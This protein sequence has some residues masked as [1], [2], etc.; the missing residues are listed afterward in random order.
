VS[1][2]S[3]GD[4]SMAIPLKYNFRSL[5]K[6]KVSTILII[7]GIALVVM[8]CIF[9][10]AMAQSMKRAIVQTGCDD[11]VIIKNKSSSSIEF[12]VLPEEVLTIIK[13]LPGIKKNNKG[14]PLVSPE[15][16]N[17]KFIK[18]GT[19]ERVIWLKIR[20]VT[21]TA[22]EVYP[23]IKI[24]AGRKP[25]RGE[26][27]IGKKVPLMFGHEFSLNDKIKVGKQEHTIVGIFE[28]EGSTY[29]GEIW[30]DKE[31]MKFDFNMKGINL[32][33]VKLQS[34][35]LMNSFIKEIDENS[36]LPTA[37]AVSEVG[38]YASLAGPATFVLV[39]GITIAVLMSL[40]A[41]FGGM[42]IMYMSIA[43]RAREIGTLRALGFTPFHTLIS[44]T[45]ESLIITVC[46]WIAGSILSITVNGY[47][48]ELFEVAFSIKITPVV[49]LSAFIVSLVIVFFGGLLPGWSA[50]R[51]QIIEALRRI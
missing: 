3:K 31:D 15:L 2:F 34:P 5:L 6:R 42:N 26:L 43:A 37:S 13:Y 45:I 7:L 29:E 9:M 27:I 36:R 11:N 4:L 1:I 23:Q 18:F 51:I 19:E 16:Y 38:Y 32:I 48:L 47:S 30:M 40:G 33:T 44:L 28:S 12:S 17:R 10:M 49:I 25:K 14:I 39:M 8:I 50:A 20:G 41:V 35:S 46:G 21:P 24:I 22:F